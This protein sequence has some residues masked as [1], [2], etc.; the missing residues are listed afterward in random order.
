[1][2]FLL[3]V[4][5]IWGSMHLYAWVRVRAY[6]RLSLLWAVVLAAA[7]IVLMVCPVAGI[8]LHRAGR[9]TS[10][11]AVA[12]VGMVWLGTFFLFFCVS[13][14]H[15]LYNA[16]LSIIQLAIPTV[17]SARLLGPYPVLVEV[18]IVALVSVYSVFEA[19]H[20]VIE[21]VQIETAKL[22]PGL[23]NLRIVQITDLHLGLSVGAGRLAAIVDA[24]RRANPDL[25]VSTGDLVD[26]RAADMHGLAEA[27]AGVQARLGKYAVTGNHEYY[28]GLDQ[29]LEFTRKAGFTVLSS[30]TV[31]PRE[32]L[33]IVGFGD[34]T[35][36]HFDGGERPDEGETLRQVR[37]GDYVVVLKH[38][39]LVR[40]ESIPLMDL[41]LSGHTHGG[42]IF[43]FGLLV[44]AFYEY[45]HGLVELGQGTHLY[46]S[47]GAGTWGP[48]MR[49]LSPPEVTVI[50][51]VRTPQARQ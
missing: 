28:A 37:Q 20:I 47:R 40:P 48:P 2:R 36:R 25:L 49:F 8:M 6:A 46:T 15:D 4:F 45:G 16:V 24:V 26:A 29:A 1:M 35:A 3:T 39:P 13:L 5:L 34:D 51:V 50:E 17:R 41:Q 10:G 31:R 44:A 14:V 11:R 43:P 22:P 32:G 19:R 30:E 12:L 38:R 18:G 21:R 42:Q 33:S 9:M 27:L 7:M 23:P